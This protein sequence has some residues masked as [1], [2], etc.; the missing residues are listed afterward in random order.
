M[1]NAVLESGRLPEASLPRAR[2]AR[3]AFLASDEADALGELLVTL[4]RADGTADAQV[5]AIW[6]LVDA[7]LA[8]PVA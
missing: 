3:D 6:M 2:A 7:C 8:A 1:F 5:D 4:D